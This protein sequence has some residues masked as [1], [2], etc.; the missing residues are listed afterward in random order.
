MHADIIPCFC[1]SLYFCFQTSETKKILSSNKVTG[2][3]NVIYRYKHCREVA[4]HKNESSLKCK[5][6]RLLLCLGFNGQIDV[7]I[8]DRFSRIFADL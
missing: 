4:Y 1:K 8:Q 3:G 2:E 5:K 6:M 7:H